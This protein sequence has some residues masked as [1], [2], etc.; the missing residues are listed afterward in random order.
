MTFKARIIQALS[1]TTGESDCPSGIANHNDVVG[2]I[3]RNHSAG[4]DERKLTDL[5]TG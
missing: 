2:H 5:Y 3:S 1:T 4:T